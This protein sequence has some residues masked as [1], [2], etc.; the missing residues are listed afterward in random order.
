MALLDLLLRAL[1]LVRHRIGGG[2][3][4]GPIESGPGYPVW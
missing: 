4:D 1:S 2:S 3:S